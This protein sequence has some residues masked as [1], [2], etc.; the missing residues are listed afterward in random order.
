M[1]ESPDA[2]YEAIDEVEIFKKSDKLISTHE[3]MQKGFNKDGDI[4]TEYFDDHS[5]I[6]RDK[7][8]ASQKVVGIV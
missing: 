6:E 1:C 2:L 3:I 8:R 5:S 4:K 7:Y